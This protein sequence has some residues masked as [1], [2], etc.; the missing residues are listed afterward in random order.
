M[1]WPTIR[2][3]LLAAT[4]VGICATGVSR[5]GEV[6]AWGLDRD[7]QVANVP[8]GSDYVAIAAGDAHGLALKSDGTIV[9]WGQN[10]DGEC[11]VP[12]GTYKAIGAGADFSLAIRADGT[13]AAWGYN[14][15]RQVSGVPEGDDFV[16]VDGGEL[17]AV[18][19]K[20]DGSIVAWGNNRWGQVSDAPTGTGFKAVAAG[21]DHAVALRSD[22]SLVAWGYWA[23]TEETPISGTFTAISAGGGFSVALK[24]DGSIVWWGDDP[25]G[26]DFDVVPAD[27]GYVALSAGYLH[28]L[29]LGRD[30]SIVG[31]G[32]GTDASGHPNWGQAVPPAGN[33]C[34]SLA[35]GLYFSLAL[36]GK[37]DPTDPVDPTDPND[38][39]VPTLVADDFDDNRLSA[40]WTLSG[41]ELLS[42]WLEEANGRL[43]LLTTAKAQGVAAYCVGTGW[44]IDPTSDFSFKVDYHYGLVSDTDGQLFVG[45]SPDANDLS[46]RYVKLGVG[47]DRQ[48]PYVWYESIDTRDMQMDFNGRRLDDGTLYVSYNAARDELYLSTSGYGD[49]NAWAVIGGVVGASWQGGPLVVFLGG[50]TDGQEIVS[51][52]AWL[53]N[54]IVETGSTSSEPSNDAVSDVYRFWSPVI[55]RHF[56]TVDTAERDKLIKEYAAVWT[57][58]GPVYKAATSAFQAGLK[59]VYRFWSPTGQSHFYTID[60]AEKD[61]LIKEYSHF[62]TFEGVAFYAYPEGVQ[63]AECVPVYRFWKNTDDSHFYTTDVSERDK[64]LKEYPDLYIYE[65]VA[66]YTYGL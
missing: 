49:P 28:C 7:G 25:Y 47:C 22:G 53:D 59:P 37:T 8:A 12:A 45:I 6:K 35:C 33:D 51:G 32:A 41:D 38:P 27:A 34:T 43:E 48:Y 2:N 44:Q 5:A 23:A 39:V 14:G 16:A 17:F 21:D 29:A 13:I 62:W 63:P 19:L 10:D 40:S 20:S 4:F 46:S 26:Y 11:Q 55:S 60:E 65:G 66:F 3:V 18:A 30:G 58:E 24:S 9:A 54:F 36:M 15:Q 64:I 56:Y 57:Y 1:R 52:D 42:C 61:Q 50:G 31:W